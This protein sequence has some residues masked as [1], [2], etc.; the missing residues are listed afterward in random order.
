MTPPDCKW[1]GEGSVL[2]TMAP[3]GETMGRRMCG[4]GREEMGGDITGD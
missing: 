3:V 1:E 4:P 2:S